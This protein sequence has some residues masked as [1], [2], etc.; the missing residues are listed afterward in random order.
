[1]DHQSLYQLHEWLV[2]VPARLESQR[3]P[4][5]P[6]ADIGGLPMIVRV[7]MNLHP[8]AQR[9]ARIVCA[10]DSAE[11]LEV[12][13]KAGF[14]AVMTR[15][16]HPSGTDRC[17]EVA[18]L[19]P[20]PLV[21]NV[22]GDEPFVDAEDLIRLCFQFDQDKTAPMGTLVYRSQSYEDFLN[23]NIVKVVPSFQGYALYFSRSPIPYH[24]DGGSQRG[25]QGFF[26]QHLGVYVYRRQSLLDY[27]SLPTADK[28]LL[29]SCEPLED[30]EKLEQLRALQN[31][32]KILLSEA[33][34]KTRG[35]DTPEDLDH[36]RKI[37]EHR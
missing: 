4:R 9:G 32:W 21:L 1:M 36:A 35:I 17:A 37:L 16:S 20:R 8:L 30:V 15:Q 2:M 14:E 26:L 24:R 10:T 29:G 22:Q 33:R 31:G 28:G 6:L 13:Q 18:G 27:G 23:P 5:K 19:I 12:V 7:M 11:V 25:F 34:H 3:L